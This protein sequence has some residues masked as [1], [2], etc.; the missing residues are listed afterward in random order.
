MSTMKRT[1]EKIR[2]HGLWLV[3]NPDGVRADLSGAI[4]R[5]ADLSGANL[6][7]AILFGADMRGA[8]MR[9]ADLRGAD[10]SGAIGC[11]RLPVGDPQ[12]YDAVAVWCH[13]QWMISAEYRQ[14][15][16]AEAKARWG[17]D[18]QGDRATGDRY[19]R[20]IEWLEQQPVPEEA[21][22]KP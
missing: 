20:A 12:G 8:D 17:S 16:V 7:G 13:D 15:A 18:Y 6:R 21:E 11:Q 5:G 22:R 3:G 9:G 10:L 14:I 4:L 19:L 2:L 1:L